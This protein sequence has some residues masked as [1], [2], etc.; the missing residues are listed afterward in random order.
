MTT[1]DIT[2]AYNDARKLLA[3]ASPDAALLYLYIR[4]GGPAG[5]AA[6]SLGLSES[7]VSCAVISAVKKREPCSR[8]PNAVSSVF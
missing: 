6:A 1:Q 8:I 7:R 5:T 4:S 3:A 2:I